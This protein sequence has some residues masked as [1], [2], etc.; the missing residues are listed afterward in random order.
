MCLYIDSSAERGIL[1]GVCRLRHVSCR[2]LWL[3]N[4]VGEKLLMVKADEGANPS[5]VATKRL[6]ISRSQSLLYLFGIWDSGNNSLVGQHDPG[7][8]FRNVPQTSA[9]QRFRISD[10]HVDWRLAC[11]F[12]VAGRT[13][14]VLLVHIVI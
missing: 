3:Q 12:R 7:R 13:C 2:V 6:S 5:D 11:F 1:S 4:V 10:Q 14:Q 9:E 8:I